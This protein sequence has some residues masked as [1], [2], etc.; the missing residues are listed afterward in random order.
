VRIHAW[1]WLC[2]LLACGDERAPSEPRPPES[3]LRDASLVRDAA[4]R[5]AASLDAATREDARVPVKGQDAAPAGPDASEPTC[6]ATPAPYL[7]RLDR[8]LVVVR[9]GDSNFVGFRAFAGERTF[10]LLRDGAPI[11]QLEVGNHRD[12]AAADAAYAVRVAG[13]TSASASS[14]PRPYVNIPLTP[15]PA[16]STPGGER[17]DYVSGTSTRTSGAVNDGSPGDL[18]GDG[19]Y[20]LVV[21]WQ[22][23]NAKDNSQAGH[24]GPVYLDAYTLDGARLWRMDLGPNIRAGA[25]YTQFL[26]Y[27]FD[28]DGRA[29]VALK[30]APGTRDGTGAYLSSGA[31]ANDDDTRDYRNASGYVLAGPEY[32]TVFSGVTGREL[33]TVPYEVARGNVR[34]WGDDYGNRVDRFLASVAFLDGRPAM[35]FGRGYYA[36]STVSAYTFDGALKKLWTLDSGQAPQLAGQ[37]AHAMQVADVD[38]DGSQELIYGAAMIRS[39]GS[40]GCS[41]GFGH[42]DAL[43]VG[44]L[45]PARPGLEVFMPH[46]DTT[47][48]TWDLRDA[49]T[50]EVIHRSSRTGVDNGRGVADDVLAAEGAEFW[51]S[52]DDA[53]RSAVSGASVGA[54]PGPTNFTVYW[55]GDAQRELLDGTVVSKPDGARLLSCSDCMSNNGTKATP[56]LSADLFGDWRE[57]IVWRTPNSDALRI[58]TTTLPTTL[59][60]P[61]LM[62]DA[63]YRAQVSAE[64][65]AYNQPPHPSF[66]LAVR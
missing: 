56:V 37:G 24:T 49:R 47:Q 48:P 45:I 15:P 35:L 14:G 4:V 9:D 27:D 62:H 13:C 10:E 8:G 21:S 30:T 50:C 3:E 63:Q 2:G 54:K 6:S 40:F 11:A 5:D 26:V 20:E 17:F 18:D 53:I 65:T 12:R 46:E 31:A 7:E 60:V 28:G 32:L 39:D 19:R 36:R 44:D 66:S 64:Q 33:A 38:G 23:S 16:G 41:T 61:T 52:A 55:D 43:H 29:E 25:H 58:Y 22:P 42:G 59:L 34:D 1:A 51:S 57:E